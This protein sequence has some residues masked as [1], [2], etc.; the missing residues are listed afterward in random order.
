MKPD[1]TAFAELLPDELPHR[2]E[3]SA[4]RLYHGRRY[5]MPSPS[6]VRADLEHRGLTKAQLEAKHGRGTQ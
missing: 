1:F 3:A 2:V 6:E 4:M 5:K